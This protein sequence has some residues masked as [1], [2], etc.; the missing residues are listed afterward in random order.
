MS[1][2]PLHQYFRQPAIYI[3]LPSDGN[4][5][6]SDALDMPANRELPVLPMTAVDE[7]T[8]RT[9]D[10]LFNGTAVVDVIKSCVP[11]IKNPWNM[12]SIDVD[13]VLAS[14]RIASYGHELDIDCRCTKCQNIDEVSIDLRTSIEKIKSPNYSESIP[15]GDLKIFFCPMTYQD[16]N[17]N[18]L[19][20]FED[21]KLMQIVEDQTASDEQKRKQMSEILKK[22]TDMT[23]KA[24]AKSISH[25]QTPESHVDNKAHISE[26]LANCDRALFNKIR[27]HIV[28]SKKTA[29][30]QPF[31][32][33][34]TSCGNEYEQLYTLDLSNFFG[35]AS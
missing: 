10:A 16:I 13:A 3:R 25:I 31:N 27:N 6:P 9:P 30:L 35:D 18:N 17:E 19:A 1:T 28:S 32:M 12:P 4:F 8:Y 24:L 23:M 22:I 11:N 7:I 20:Q 15:H 5:Y 26:W 2:N 33:K 21:Q 29:E 14:I 34:C